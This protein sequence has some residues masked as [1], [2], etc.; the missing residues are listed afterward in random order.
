MP[1]AI[2]LAILG[3][4]VATAG[5]GL[6]ASHHAASVEANAA[7]QNNALQQQIYEENKGLAMPYINAGNQ[8]EGALSGFLGLGG[9]PVA[10]Q[11]AFDNYLNSTGYQFALNQG[12]Q[13][14]EQNKAARGMLNS[15]ATL[16]ALDAYGTGLAQQYGQQY[17]GNLQNLT[18]TGQR[19]ASS[20]TGA[21]QN[22]ANAVGT[23]NTNAANVSANAGI[24]SANAFSGALNSGV[25][26]LGYANGGNAFGPAGGASSYAPMTTPSGVGYGIGG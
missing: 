18:D 26:A 21:G 22:Y 15:G 20:L 7:A 9:D 23:N 6:I 16:K 19:S 5:A 14:A 3:A 25:Q 17:V 1:I 8:A 4:G 2:P 24:A 12:E 11:K 13:A 10:E